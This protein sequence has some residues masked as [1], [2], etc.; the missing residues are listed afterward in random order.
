MNNTIKELIEA[1]NAQKAADARLASAK[2][3]AVEYIKDC[4]YDK[5]E[6]EGYT[7]SLKEYKRQTHKANENICQLAAELEAARQ[8]LADANALKIY[9]LQQKIYDLRYE[10][11]SIVN[12]DDTKKLEIL[13]REA[14]EELKENANSKLD[15]VVKFN[16]KSANLLNFVD[17]RQYQDLVIAGAKAKQ[18]CGKS[19]GK[20]AVANF[21]LSWAHTPKSAQLPLM[22]AWQLRLDEHINYWRK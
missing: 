15:V 2:M 5:I 4:G 18:I 7:I 11:H 9:E 20:A 6:I 8:K 1:Q 12:N 13:I 10:L 19:L 3:K 22:E 17:E 21:I 16:A 14:E